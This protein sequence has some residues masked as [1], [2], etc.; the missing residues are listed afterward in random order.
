LKKENITVDVNSDDEDECKI[1]NV[2]TG[3]QTS[4]NQVIKI[5]T[6]QLGV[7]VE[8]TYVKNPIS[9]YVQHTKADMS[10]ASSELGYEPKWRNVENGIRELLTLRSS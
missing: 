7:D 9:N 3:I 4:F 1:Y 10:L 6:H 8:P 5:I 2:G